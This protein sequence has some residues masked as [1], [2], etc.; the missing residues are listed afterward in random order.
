MYYLL[1]QILDTVFRRTA[2]K[3]ESQLLLPDPGTD[4]H[5]EEVMYVLLTT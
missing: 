4:A 2:A 3:E 5:Y 1:P